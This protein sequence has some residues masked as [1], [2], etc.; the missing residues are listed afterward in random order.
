[1]ARWCLSAEKNS[2]RARLRPGRRVSW[3]RGTL[4]V[5]DQNSLRIGSGR[6]RANATRAFPITNEAGA[7]VRDISPPG[8][9]LPHRR[10]DNL[11]I[12]GGGSS[13]ST[14]TIRMRGCASRRTDGPIAEVETLDGPCNEI[15]R[16]IARRKIRWTHPM[17]NERW[18]ERPQSRFCGDADEFRELHRE[19]GVI[20][21]PLLPRVMSEM[22]DQQ[23]SGSA[24]RQSFHAGDAIFITRTI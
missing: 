10:W 5:A 23:G 16:R 11:A 19:D 24:R 8:C 18:L 22:N 3:A 9:F 12:Q 14:Q 7:A 6:V 2:R 4:G 17:P 1:M 20:P 13:A 21:P 15:C